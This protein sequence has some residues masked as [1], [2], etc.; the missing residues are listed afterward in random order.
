MSSLN[1]NNEIIFLDFVKDEDLP[2]IF[3]LNSFN[4]A[5]FSGQQISAWEAFK[6][7]V[8]V[9]YSD[10]FGIKRYT[11]TVYYIDQCYLKQWPMQL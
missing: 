2:F 8:P 11:K 6:I 7:E 4:D 3:K 10:I 5:N 1:L 9:I